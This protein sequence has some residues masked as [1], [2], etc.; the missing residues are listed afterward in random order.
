MEP[1]PE[2]DCQESDVLLSGRFAGS[3]L[4]LIDL[5]GS[6]RVSKTGATGQRLKEGNAINKSLLTLG[7]V[8]YKLSEGGKGHIPFRDS[9]LTRL[10]SSS[11]GGNAK[12]AVV[13]TIS[14]ASR[15]PVRPYTIALRQP[16]FL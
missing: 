8:I 14:P 10:L 5:A 7:T 1:F 16:I 11:L 12:T 15:K 6:E 4:N 2:N 3:T 9:K 13:V